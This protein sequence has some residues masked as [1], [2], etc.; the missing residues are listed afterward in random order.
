M[1]ILLYY[2]IL[3][4]FI[5]GKYF[6]EGNTI[7]SLFQYVSALILIISEIIEVEYLKHIAIVIAI[8]NYIFICPVLYTLPKYKGAV[9]LRDNYSKR[10]NKELYWA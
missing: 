6:K 10:N 8:L 2:F 3:V 9:G 5:V 1:N 4:A 7:G